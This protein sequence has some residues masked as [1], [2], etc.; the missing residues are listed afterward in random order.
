MHKRFPMGPLPEDLHRKLLNL[1]TNT[2]TAGAADAEKVD[3]KSSFNGETI[4]TVL[5]GTVE[6]VEYAF[7]LARA[8]QQKWA[9]T[10][11]EQRQEIFRAFHD[12]VLDNRELL[13]DIVQLET[14]KNRASALDEVMDVAINARYYANNVGKHIGEKKRPGALPIAT[15]SV[16]QHIPKGVV[17]QITPWNYP[18]ALGISDAIP[19]LLA[20]NGV[21]A[22]PDSNTP[23]SC[24][25]AVLFLYE[26]GLPRDLMQVVTG[27]GTVVGSAIADHCDYL[28]FTGSTKT[29]RILGRQVGERLIGYSAEL[30]GKN[31]LIIAKDADLDLVMREITSACFSNSGQL[32]VSI[33]RIYVE[34]PVYTEVVNRMKVAVEAM[35]IGSGFNWDIDMGSLINQT[36]LDTVSRFVDEAREHGAKVLAGGKARPDLGPY[37]YE[38][39]V[40]VDVP[41][42][43]PVLSDEVFGPVVYIEK[44]ASLEE[45][46]EKANG[47]SYGL[48]ASVFAAP[49]TGRKIAS[50]IEAGGVGIND[51]YA[52]SWA[53][54][55]VPLGGM[56]Q[57][58]MGRR[59]GPDGLLK[60]TETRNVAEQRFI[61]MRGPA[62]ISRKVYADAMVTALKLG[63]KLR[64]LP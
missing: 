34:E 28:M 15:R 56:K 18:L 50:Q 58:G 8:A 13:M 35:K 39:T 51:G 55:S 59:H 57:S 63:K 54:V 26:S 42:G 31:P 16:E 52:A 21:V 37:F 41:A 46:V 60:Y 29:G 53:T 4:G 9:Q 19:A 10:P 43:T 6:D 23:F 7:E 12:R 5:S 11:I 49:E 45:A 17:G 1:T 24:L 61:S 2:K 40:L 33:E 38:P 36:Q 44:V 25:I 3:V 30:G 22:K 27:S 64:F 48:N 47:T 62:V 32:C 14:G 20:G